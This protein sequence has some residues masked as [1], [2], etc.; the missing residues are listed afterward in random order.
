VDGTVKGSELIKDWL[1]ESR[2]AAQLVIDTYGEPHEA[3]G[4]LLTWH[5]VDPLEAGAVRP[6]PGAGHQGGREGPG[7]RLIPRR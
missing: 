3:T 1:E 7:Q 2:E 5:R 6:G 4:S